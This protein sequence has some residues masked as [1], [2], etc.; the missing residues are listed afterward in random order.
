[1]NDI[2]YVGFIQ[3]QITGP[4]NRTNQNGLFRLMWLPRVEINTI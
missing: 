4:G 1:M 3:E 2:C